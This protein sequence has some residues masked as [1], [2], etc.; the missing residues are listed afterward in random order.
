MPSKPNC[1]HGVQTWIEQPP[2]RG[3]VR[4]SVWG[5]VSCGYL[6]DEEDETFIELTDLDWLG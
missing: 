5:C 2:P 6:F 1:E 4:R 3:V